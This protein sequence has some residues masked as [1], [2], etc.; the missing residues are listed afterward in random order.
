MPSKTNII[1]SKYHGLHQSFPSWYHCSTR[2][3]SSNQVAEEALGELYNNE[4]LEQ[5][6]LP[7][8]E[9]LYQPSQQHTLL[10]SGWIINDNN[11]EQNR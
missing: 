10:E 8:A 2:L 5:L 9:D 1:Q 7:S 11:N 6:Y 4:T 3:T